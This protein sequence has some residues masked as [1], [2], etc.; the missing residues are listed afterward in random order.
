MTYY[1]YT[2]CPGCPDD[3]WTSTA[4]KETVLDGLI[5]SFPDGN[6]P[7][8]CFIVSVGNSPE[9][10]NG[11]IPFDWADNPPAYNSFVSCEECEG[12]AP[13][14]EDC[15]DCPAGYTLVG[16]ICEKITI[17]P[18]DCSENLIPVCK[19]FMI[20]GN[21]GSYP[22]YF[23]ESVD[24]SNPAN[25]PLFKSSGSYDIKYQ[26]S[27]PLAQT[28]TI[29]SGDPRHTAIWLNRL[30]EIGVWGPKTESSTFPN[31]LPPELWADELT[32]PPADLDDML[33]ED[34]WIGFAFCVEIPETR[35]YAVFAAGDNEVR[36][37]VDGQMLLD[38]GGSSSGVNTYRASWIVEVTLTA[39]THVFTLE[40]RNDNKVGA[41]GCE[42]YSAPTSDI[43]NY[44]SLAELQAVTV[45]SSF[46]L[47][48]TD[49]FDVGEE[50]GGDPIYTETDLSSYLPVV[51]KIGLASIILTPCCGGAQLETV[52]SDPSLSINW[53]ADISKV[54]KFNNECY[55]LSNG[56]YGGFVPIGTQPSGFIDTPTDAEVTVLNATSCP[57]AAIEDAECDCGGEETEVIPVP[58]PGLVL[59]L[60]GLEG[61]WTVSIPPNGECVNPF[62]VVVT[63]ASQTSC[64]DCV[65]GYEL[66]DCEDTSNVIYTETDLSQFVAS[67]EVIQIQQYPGFCFQV[68][69]ANEAVPNPQE[70]WPTVSFISCE[71][72]NLTQYLLEDCAGNEPS[73]ITNSDLEQ[74]VGGIVSLQFCPEI[75]WTVSEAPQISQ[76]P[77]T[78][79]VQNSYSDCESCYP[80]P[81]PEVEVTYKYRSVQPGYCTP[82]CSKEFYEKVTCK[83]AD[84]M[85]KK[86]VGLRYGIEMCCQDDIDRIRRDKAILDNKVL[87]VPCNELVSQ[88]CGV[89]EI[90]TTSEP[91]LFGEVVTFTK[92]D[93]GDEVD[94]IIPGVLE[95]TRG[96]NKGIYNSVSETTYDDSGYTSPA[97]TQWASCRTEDVENPPS[98]FDQNDPL[99]W[100]TYAAFNQP[101]YGYW[102]DARDFG[103]DCYFNGYDPATNYIVGQPFVM[104]HVPSG[105]Y[106]RITF[107]AWTGS[108]AGGGFTYERQEFI[109][110]PN[111]GVNIT[112]APCGTTQAI[113][114]N[115][116]GDFINQICYS[117]S[118]I[119]EDLGGLVTTAELEEECD[120]T[121]DFPPE[122]T[123]GCAT[124][125]FTGSKFGTTVR[126]TDCND[127][128]REV[129]IDSLNPWTDCII[130]DEYEFI[131]ILELAKLLS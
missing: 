75:C 38:L 27:T 65:I 37:S 44:T 58:I 86:M 74:Y 35:P 17:V 45:F 34:E 104:K 29:P 23:F 126:Y 57:D 59:E 114:E 89:L 55:T 84:A 79:V 5:L 122:S 102:A 36:W 42:V 3:P 82:G 85:Y 112:Y 80:E 41:F 9:L 20:P 49:V 46:D 118:Y 108:N 53:T 15:A 21:Y 107:T 61:C 14:S 101:N 56:T 106:W 10:P 105:R 33:P 4:D 113:T 54:V 124:Y 119:I 2:P 73:F 31:C 68:F 72:C 40:G 95:I 128:V 83:Y 18:A 127:I 13:E 12:T 70:V 98:V 30:N 91:R 76:D 52:L 78:V 47:V 16:D 131:G 125:T 63:D 43:F 111:D 64:D 81:E 116:S 109:N 25:L 117:G 7:D 94:V 50:S 51:E 87:E 121:S 62:P 28:G 71:E 92:T 11:T 32:Y 129:G 39:G 1:L 24:L 60:Q 123:I 110:L 97:D 96:N 93:F 67:G 130:E 48:G 100:S 19:G 26:D 22:A 99:T 120:P 8:C 103:D 66:R 90:I 69:Q 115:F 77:Q 6:N 88:S